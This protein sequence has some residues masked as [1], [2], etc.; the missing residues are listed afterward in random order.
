MNDYTV[1]MHIAP[2]GKRYIGITHL[3]PEY[4]YGKNGSGYRRCTFFYRAIEKYGWNEFQHI[5][6]CTNLSKE[7]ACKKEQELIATYQSNNPEFGYNCSL[8]GES[9]S[10]GH[11]FTEEQRKKISL[12]TKGR[13]VSTET[14]KKIG[15]ANSKSLKG[16]KLPE[17]VKRKIS[18][19][20]AR[21][22]KGK[23]LPDSVLQRA[24]EVNRGNSYHLG[25]KHSDEAKQKMRLAKLGKKRG[26]WTDAERKAHMDAIERKRQEKAKYSSV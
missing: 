15:T 7:E 4:R 25:K 9:G 12:A 2:N 3:K 22:W 26:S 20:N 14:R 11:I 18:V 1:Y 24:V 23:K 19:N 10:F 21:Y 6:V 17:E 16:R 13:I 8:G 5:I